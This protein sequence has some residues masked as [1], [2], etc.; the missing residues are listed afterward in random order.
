MLQPSCH[1]NS[2]FCTV[3]VPKSL[4][5]SRMEKAWSNNRSFLGL[6][7]CQLLEVEQVFCAVSLS[8]KFLFKY[9]YMH[10]LNQFFAPGVM[11]SLILS[12]VQFLIPLK[13]VPSLLTLGANI[14]LIL[15]TTSCG[16]ALVMVLVVLRSW[17]NPDCCRMCNSIDCACPTS[18][19]PHFF[20]VIL[21]HMIS[22][23]LAELNKFNINSRYM[24][25]KSVHLRQYT[26]Q[27][28]WLCKSTHHRR[29]NMRTIF[30]ILHELFFLSFSFLF[31]FLYF[32]FFLELIDFQTSG[33]PP[34]LR[35][36][37]HQTNYYLIVDWPVEWIVRGYLVYLKIL[38]KPIPDIDSKYLHYQAF[39]L[40]F[41]PRSTRL[42]PLLTM[43]R[44]SAIIHSCADHP[45]GGTSKDR[46]LLEKKRRKKNDHWIDVFYLALKTGFSYVIARWILI[47]E[48]DGAFIWLSILTYLD[49]MRRLPFAFGVVEYRD[50]F[51]EMD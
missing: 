50:G 40:E 25:T 10:Q 41:Q 38:M 29:K 34:T 46:Q 3:T 1:P 27:V 9:I 43:D 47:L 51:G 19:Q 4:V 49:E 2:I 7:A 37:F 20:E 15:L 14:A 39:L 18:N 21:D 35:Q 26:N 17:R 30:Q 48:G 23:S 42:L 11:K 6:S 8:Y 45:A 12:L 16:N 24:D 36:S 33:L 32:F 5:E 13:I 31:L 28:D 22:T 44:S